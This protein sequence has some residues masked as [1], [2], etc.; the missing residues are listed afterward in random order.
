MEL[1]DRICERQIGNFYHYESIASFDIPDQDNY[2]VEYIEKL[3][4]EKMEKV[5]EQ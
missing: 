4:I 2:S 3:R 1:D 5:S